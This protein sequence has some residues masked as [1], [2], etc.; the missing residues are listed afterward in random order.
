MKQNF[1]LPTK[2][3]MDT[4]CVAA[5]AKQLAALGTKALIVTG[6]HSAHVNGSLDDVTQA[7]K[8][9]GR[10]YKVFDKVEPNP[11]VECVYAGAKC[12]RDAGCDFV[13]AIGGGSPMDSA[14][15]I[16]MLAIQDIPEAKIFSG[17]YKERLPLCC[18]PT[19]A[20]TGSEVTQYSILTNDSA[21][22]KTSLAS[23]V[24]F[25]D[26]AL[27]DSKYMASLPRSTMINTVL[28]SM[29]HSAEGY[30]SVKSTA[31]SDTLALKAMRIIGRCLERL[32]TGGL[33]GDDRAD[34]LLAST[35]G[36][37]VIVHTGTTAVHAM[38]YSLTY[39]RHIDHGRAN[40]ILLTEFLKRAERA[41]PERTAD[42]LTA[43]GF[44]SFTDMERK[45]NLLLGKKEKI[46]GEELSEYADIAIKAGNIANCLWKPERSDLYDIYLAS[47]STAAH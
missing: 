3:I 5:N 20:G 44:S 36:G 33:N 4:D 24:L 16:A 32:G 2:I 21:K 25:P 14:K 28:D 39:F 45:L 31:F 41:C 10:A 47:F 1:Y 43:L 12:A 26:L 17:G 35:M 15:A 23:P 30:L 34:L 7:L 37:M 22:T 46:T 6:A 42:I 29:S 19:T 13:I 18:I 11:T 40:G 9:E 38:G 8:S 27:L